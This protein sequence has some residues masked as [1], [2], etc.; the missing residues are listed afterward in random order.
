MNFSHHWKTCNQFSQQVY[1]ILKLN[2]CDCHWGYLIFAKVFENKK[3]FG[4]ES[5]CA[6]I[7]YLPWEYRHNKT[8]FEI[9]GYVGI[10]IS[11]DIEVKKNV[12][13]HFTITVKP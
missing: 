2:F 8:L 6:D 13:V 11:I 12:F 5:Y 7:P 1:E 10:P 9:D 4:I 3:Y